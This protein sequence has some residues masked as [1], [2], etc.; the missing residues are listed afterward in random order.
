MSD[1]PRLS[2]LNLNVSDL[3]RSV[4]FYQ[5]VF[6]LEVLHES[7]D[8]IEADGRRV[9]VRQAVLTAPGT[10]DLLALTQ[11]DPFPVGP[12]GLNHFGFVFT[13]NDHVRVAIERAVQLGGGI[14][15]QGERDG[16]GVHEVFAYIRD[17]DGY[18][19]EF[20]TQEILLRSTR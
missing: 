16:N 20:S 10:R 4:C 6:G 3:R 2:H 19:I 14:I 12:G 9:E 13:S 8:E 5:Q 1:A 17:P 7:T 11:A 15:R 18:A